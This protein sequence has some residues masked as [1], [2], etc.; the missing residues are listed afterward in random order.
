MMK[1]YELLAS[2]PTPDTIPKVPADQGQ[3]NNIVGGVLML[4]GVVC[5]VFIII[6]AIQYITSQGD[7]ANI[8]KAK[9]SIFY[10]A[11]GLI[12]VGTAFL[13]VQVV[14]GVFK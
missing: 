8:K 1:P 7:A 12:F 10:A 13:I 3:I 4:A 14:I 9:D 2:I 5:V 11:F 6:G